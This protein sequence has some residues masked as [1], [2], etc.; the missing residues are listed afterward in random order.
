MTSTSY[1]TD[2]PRSS[3]ASLSDPYYSALRRTAQ[4][5]RRRRTEPGELEEYT[6]GEGMPRSLH[7][8]EEDVGQSHCCSCWMPLQGGV[9]WD[10][11]WCRSR[12]Q[13]RME[14][15]KCDVHDRRE[16]LASSHH[17]Q[18]SGCLPRV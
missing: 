13:S 10:G 17:A 11:C 8:S 18:R 15:V 5:Q 12:S 16:E 4:A 6:R 9:R 2:L 3:Y 1:P 14:F 7:C